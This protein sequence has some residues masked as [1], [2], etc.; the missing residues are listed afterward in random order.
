MEQGEVLNELKAIRQILE[1][2]SREPLRREIERVATTP[3]R[4]EMWRLCDGSLSNEEIAKQIN[5]TLRSVQYFVQDGI[6]IGV[7]T[8]V[9]RGTPQRKMD[10]IPPEWARYEKKGD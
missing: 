2:Q 3:E 8:Q 4:K 7:L 1:I 9:K 6:A 10:Y 5:V